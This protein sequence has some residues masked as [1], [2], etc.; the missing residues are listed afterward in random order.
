MNSVLKI[1]ILLLSFL[2]I[3]G[4]LFA[5]VPGLH[6]FQGRLT[7]ISGDIVADGM[8]SIT[9][10]IYDAEAGGTSKWT[11]THPAVPV[12]D[13]IFGVLLGSVNQLDNTVFSDPSRFLEVSFGTTTIT[14]RIPFTT[15]SYSYRVGS[16]DGSGGGIIKGSL[17]IA[18]DANK[19]NDGLTITDASGNKSIDIIVSTDKFAEISL[20][21][22]VDNKNGFADDIKSVSISD[23]GIVIFNGSNADTSASFS[24]DETG[25]G[26]FSL[27]EPVDTKGITMKSVEVSDAGI[28]IFKTG[29][30]DT[31][32]SLSND[33]TGSGIISIYEP[34]DNKDPFSQGSKKIEMTPTGLFMFGQTIFDTSLIVAPNGD[35]IGLGQITMGENSAYGDN[36][37]VLG[38][39][40]TADGDSSAIG[41]GAGNST[42]GS[43]T[44]IAGGNSNTANGNYSSISGGV[45]NTTNGDYS[46]IAGGLQNIAD[47]P[48]SSILGGTANYTL[49]DNALA[50]GYRAQAN[51]IGSFVWADK[52]EEDFSTTAD[53]QFIIRATG[54]VGIGTNSPTGALDVVAD[55]G[56]GSVNLPESSVSSIEILNEPGLSSSRQALE[57]TIDAQRS[58]MAD[59]VV[60]TITIPTDGYIT[61]R[62]TGTVTTTGTNKSNSTRVQIDEFE[63]GVS[64]VPYFTQ[65][66]LGDQD[67]P[68]A[69]NYFSISAERVYFKEAGTYEFRLEAVPA[70]GN[71]SGAQSTVSNGIIT[72]MFVPTAYGSVNE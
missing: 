57:I 65:V 8:Y 11:E 59:I 20:Y 22:P 42:F 19:V 72:A 25:S 31:S 52:T 34:V 67:S 64:E 12:K 24:K 39:N 9:F 18:Q 45:E 1:F 47:G 15:V 3:S 37:S 68:S 50:A 4:S 35:I 14:P 63:G 40:N 6:S 61:V 56:D 10:S 29:T 13:G 28:I 21:E 5:D 16:I 33:I 46:F 41:G 43:N 66:G 58:T 70:P 55:A 60:T 49:G 48:F 38:F 36:T 71:G 2:I 44:V 7:N 32:V 54:G 17:I 30:E 26:T 23:N 69:I 27:Y 53:N 62:G 51:H